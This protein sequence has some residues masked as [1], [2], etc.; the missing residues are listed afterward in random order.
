MKHFCMAC[1]KGKPDFEVKS[2]LGPYRGTYLTDYT[3][4]P[5]CHCKTGT[6]ICSSKGTQETVGSWIDCSSDY[7]GR[8]RTVYSE[9]KTCSDLINRM[10][11]NRYTKK[12]RNE[13]EI[14]VS[15]VEQ[16]IE[17]KYIEFFDEYNSHEKAFQATLD[18]VYKNKK[19]IEFLKKNR[20]GFGS[21]W[22]GKED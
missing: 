1:G 2:V 13:N 6:I 14:V 20:T 15:F 17:N 19:L 16:R 18:W 12:H 22:F 4:C 8:D 5:F 7:I 9:D 10:K 11:Q 3:F 21:H